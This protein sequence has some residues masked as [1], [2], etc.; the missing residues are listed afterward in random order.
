MS[1]PDELVFVDPSTPSFIWFILQA[2]FLSYVLRDQLPFSAEQLLPLSTRLQPLTQILEAAPTA[3]AFER[4]SLSSLSAECASSAL[5]AYD[6]LNYQIGSTFDYNLRAYSKLATTLLENRSKPSREHKAREQSP[7]AEKQS[8]EQSHAVSKS[9]LPL[10]ESP[11]KHAT[12]FTK[13]RLVEI[14]TIIYCSSFPLHRDKAG[15]E[16]SNA[17]ACKQFSPFYPSKKFKNANNRKSLPLSFRSE[18]VLFKHDSE[19]IIFG[20]RMP[21]TNPPNWTGPLEDPI[22]EKLNI[23]LYS[24][25]IYALVAVAI[26]NHELTYGQQDSEYVHPEIIFTGYGRGGLLATWMAYRYI[27]SGHIRDNSFNLVKVATWA[28]TEF[29]LAVP[30]KDGNMDIVKSFAQLHALLGS[31]NHLRWTTDVSE[32]L[33]K[34]N[35]KEIPPSGHFRFMHAGG[36][37]IAIPSALYKATFNNTAPRVFSEDIIAEYPL[38]PWHTKA[39]MICKSANVETAIARA[40][41]SRAEDLQIIQGKRDRKPVLQYPLL[42]RSSAYF[43]YVLSPF[44]YVTRSLVT[45]FSN[46]SVSWDQHVYQLQAHV[47]HL[48]VF[49]KLCISEYTSGIETLLTREATQWI[50]ILKNGLQKVFPRDSISCTLIGSVGKD[51]FQIPKIDEVYDFK[52]RTWHARCDVSYAKGALKAFSYLGHKS[53]DLQMDFF[54]GRSQAL[55]RSEL[56]D[57]ISWKTPNRSTA[58]STRRPLSAAHMPV[59]S[60]G[61]TRCYAA[62]ASK[63][64]TAWLSN[65]FDNN[66]LRLLKK[67]IPHPFSALASTAFYWSSSRRITDSMHT[68][69]LENPTIF[70]KVFLKNV[71]YLPECSAMRPYDRLLRLRTDVA[72]PAKS[73]GER[74]TQ[75]WGKSFLHYRQVALRFFSNQLNKNPQSTPSSNKSTW[76]ILRMA[77]NALSR[78]SR[79]I[80]SNS[81]APSR[82]ESEVTHRVVQAS[83]STVNILEDQALLG[84]IVRSLSVRPSLAYA[85]DCTHPLNRWLRHAAPTFLRSPEFDRICSNILLIPNSNWALSIVPSTWLPGFDLSAMFAQAA[86][87]QQFAVFTAT[88][89]SAGTLAPQLYWWSFQMY[90]FQLSAVAVQ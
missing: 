26:K 42:R 4:P 1:S 62:I 49:Y 45:D 29:H 19:T 12:Q 78:F 5:L 18:H 57:R 33:L 74:A 56:R 30:S 80:G 53:V 59:L 36:V 61:L 65:V 34:S 66:D 90:F 46:P 32:G 27:C 83:T 7:P 60:D 44:A 86:A 10:P 9:R 20:F 22:A 23:L 79:P 43:D 48:D 71:P 8:T 89:A 15:I 87:E 72:M 2:I 50:E 54:G 70:A 39:M 82:S 51:V 85:R 11:Y 77:S 16:Y 47:R 68:T 28:E 37:P 6:Q 38:N 81:L 63:K 3:L 40:V 73:A 13:S 64:N 14:N 25:E 67:N 52:K 55:L 17:E 35:P 84:H 75:Q 69:C 76:L 41:E 31:E 21:W 88:P 24:A 58:S